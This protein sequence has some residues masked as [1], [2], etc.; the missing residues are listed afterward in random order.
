MLLQANRR[1]LLGWGL[2][3][4]CLGAVAR[5]AQAQSSDNVLG[6]ILGDKLWRDEGPFRRYERLMWVTYELK[7]VYRDMFHDITDLNLPETAVYIAV[8]DRLTAKGTKGVALSADDA[9]VADA[10]PAISK[11]FD[12]NLETYRRWSESIGVNPEG[13]LAS[14]LLSAQALLA[15]LKAAAKK[16][17]AQQQNEEDDDDDCAIFYP[18]C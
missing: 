12:A 1:Q 2:A 8:V 7:Y 16:A 9:L 18:F 4:C 13:P 14:D 3:S 6:P 11:A 5:P 15:L 17:A 10:A